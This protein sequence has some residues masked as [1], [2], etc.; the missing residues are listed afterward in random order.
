[1]K[2]EDLVHVYQLCIIYAPICIHWGPQPAVNIV[3]FLRFYFH[4]FHTQATLKCSKW[5]LICRL[6]VTSNHVN[7]T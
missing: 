1:M 4:S 3:H 5:A 2:R 6:F 7:I